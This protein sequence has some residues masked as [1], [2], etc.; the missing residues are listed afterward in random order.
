MVGEC[1]HRGVCSGVLEIPLPSVLQ[2]SPGHGSGN[3]WN[4][5]QP[6]SQA[7][8]ILAPNTL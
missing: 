2:L 3:V 6:F 7:G 4:I 5:R 8:C 1:V